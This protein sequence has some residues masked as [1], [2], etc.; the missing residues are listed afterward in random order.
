MITRLLHPLP[1]IVMFAVV[2][3]SPTGPATPIGASSGSSPSA[4]SEPLP[5]PSASSS[6]SAASPPIGDPKTLTISLTPLPTTLT[7]DGKL[8]EWPRAVDG[9]EGPS[10]VR[11]A[12]DP[13][14]A[15]IA[16]ELRGEAASTRL[17]IRFAAPGETIGAASEPSPTS[18]KAK[19]SNAPFAAM[20]TPFG[21]GCMVSLSMCPHPVSGFAERF[22]AEFVLDATGV[23]AVSR[24]GK[25]GAPV[26]GV[27]V[28]QAGGTTRLEGLLPP[29]SLPLASTVPIR[30]VGLAAVTSKLG[31][32]VPASAWGW[33]DASV[34][35][36]GEE[37]EARQFARIAEAG[38]VRTAYQPGSGELFTLGCADGNDLVLQRRAGFSKLS[39]LGDVEVGAFFDPAL[40]IATRKNSVVVQTFDFGLS[41][42]PKVAV[43]G[44]RLWVV[45]INDGARTQLRVP[46]YTPRF[47]VVAVDREGKIREI[48]IEQHHVGYWY[49]AVPSYSADLETFSLSGEVDAAQGGGAELV[50]WRYD[51][52]SDSYKVIKHARGDVEPVDVASLRSGAP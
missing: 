35:F 14:G 42:Q 12:L 48:G 52:A 4:S 50:T 24:D 47:T 6:A 20:R 28:L 8:D 43:R 46:Q 32:S 33:R 1:A 23:R 17:G 11:V 34:S 37:A 5:T 9:T 18:C 38:G 30:R 39:S 25:A 31:T 27:R 19:E 41:E 16:A 2:G 21:G 13:T 51:A 26:P 49:K 10:W 40:G 45:G 7:I 15:A 3:C 29:A 44:D 36:A 22:E